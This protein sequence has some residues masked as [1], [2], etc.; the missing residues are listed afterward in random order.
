M[1]ER[2]K[3]YSF[4]MILIYSALLAARTMSGLGKTQH[5]LFNCWVK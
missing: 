4:V 2:L 3:L 5:V 1:I